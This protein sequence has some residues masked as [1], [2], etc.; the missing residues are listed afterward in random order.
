VA[1]ERRP[2]RSPSEH[3]G[4]HRGSGGINSRPSPPSPQGRSVRDDRPSLQ[5]PE[6]HGRCRACGRPDRAHSRLEISQKTAR[7]P[8]ASTAH[9]SFFCSFRNRSRPNRRPSTFTRFLTTADTTTPGGMDR[10]PESRSY[11]RTGPYCG[12]RLLRSAVDTSAVPQT[13]HEP[14]RSGENASLTSDATILGR[15]SGARQRVE[16]PIKRYLP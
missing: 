8:Q 7:F 1:Q 16:L 9:S 12:A 13:A 4:G 10:R 6:G 3:R 5:T 2:A 14:V 15:R 11:F